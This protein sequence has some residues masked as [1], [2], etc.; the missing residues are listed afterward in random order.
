[1]FCNLFI[2][3]CAAYENMR[4]NIVEWG[5]PQMRIRYVRIACWIPKATQ[6]L[7]HCVIFI[8][9]PLQQLLQESASIICYISI[10]SLVN[11]H[12]I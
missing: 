2:E 7:A 9:L 4:K 11:S 10:D 1:M 12:F 6:I 3:S 8:A 5:R